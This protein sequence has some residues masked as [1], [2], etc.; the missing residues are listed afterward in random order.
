MFT[1]PGIH[2]T[3]ANGR[4]VVIYHAVHN[5]YH[6]LSDKFSVATIVRERDGWK[7]Y[8]RDP[9][10]TADDLQLLEEIMIK[11]EAEGKLP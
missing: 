7:A 8:T 9:D 3:D 11:A 10:T 6:V 5:T 1:P 4:Q 2:F